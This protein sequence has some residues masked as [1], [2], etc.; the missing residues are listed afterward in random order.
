MKIKIVVTQKPAKH[1]LTSCFLKSGSLER[2]LNIEIDALLRSCGKPQSIIQDL[3]LVAS[4]VYAIDKTFTR[5]KYSN[6]NWTRKFN[7]EIPVLKYS[8]W[9]R[10]SEELSDCISFLTGDIWTFKFI[11]RNRKLYLPYKN[12]RTL[13]YKDFNPGAVCL[14]SGGLDSLTGAINF[15]ESNNNNLLLVGHHDIIG[16]PKRDQGKVYEIIKGEYK[17]RIEL[18]QMLVS[19][20]PSGDDITYRSRSF[21]F[22]SLGVAAAN[23]FSNKLPVMIPENGVISLN[24]PLTP[25]R[26]GSCST[27]TVHPYYL[28]RLNSILR[29][30]GIFNTVSNPLYKLTKGECISKCENYNLL[31][32]ALPST[33]SCAKRKHKVHW[34]RTNTDHCGFCMPCIY[35]RAA[36]KK[37][38][39]KNEIYGLDICKN[40]I[41]VENKNSIAD[42]LKGIMA[43][44][45]NKHSRKE[46]GTILSANGKLD[47]DKLPE[48]SD[49][50]FRGM[51]EVHSL[52]IDKKNVNINK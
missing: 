43:F 26:R 17:K 21:I 48:Y 13:F 33:N 29:K 4:S 38:G 19:Q 1:R 25:A 39:I 36:L 35:R 27:R 2:I 46:I 11:R 14:F 20:D 47:L 16:G 8:K 31:M 42:D 15:L 3:L 5:E 22:I 30:L 50:V 12:N 41:D 49:T 28:K 10:V 6:D 24:P 32:Q 9:I 52:L 7:V 45:E 44:L 18:L 40:E 23:A 51:K 34:N 37:N